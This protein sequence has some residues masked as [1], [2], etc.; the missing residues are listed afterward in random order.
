MIAVEP[1][2]F[3][4]PRASYLAHQPEIDAAVQ[5]V[6]NSG[7]YILGREGEAFEREFARYLG[8]PHALGVASGTDAVHLAL[9]ACGVGPSDVVATV[10]H[11]AVATVAAIELAG[12][13]PLLVDVDSDTYTLDPTRLEETVRRHAERARIKAV[14]PV[15]LYGHIAAFSFYPTKNLGALGDA[16]A[17]ATTDPLLAANVR[18]LRE[19][20]WKERYI[21]SRAGL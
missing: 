2:A 10:S 3:A 13:T 12:A 8:L 7:A 11:T 19:Y 9:R 17:V 15:H 4:D 18:L 14:V 6:L 5:R 20:G 16:G 1:I 21:S